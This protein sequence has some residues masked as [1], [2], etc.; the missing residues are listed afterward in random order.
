MD[1][2]KR[3]PPDELSRL[4]RALQGLVATVQNVAPT[5]R[6]EPLLGE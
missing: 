1:A 4:T 2:L 3:L 6:G 5:A